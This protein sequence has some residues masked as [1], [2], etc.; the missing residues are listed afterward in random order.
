MIISDTLSSL[1]IWI[2]SLCW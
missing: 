2:S 1:L